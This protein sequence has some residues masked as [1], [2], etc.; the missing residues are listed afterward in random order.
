MVNTE[1]GLK[2]FFSNPGQILFFSAFFFAPALS[3][4]FFGWLNGLLAVP[5]F[6]LLTVNGFRSGL[7]PLRISIMIAGIGALLVHRLEFFLFSL[8]LIPLGYSLFKS[9]ATQESAA[10]T[11]GKGVAVLGLTW[12]VFWGVYGAVM[13]INPYKHLLEMLDLG[14]QQSLEVYT[15]KEAGLPPE[16]IFAV[17][18]VFSGLRKAIPALLP[19]LLAS[20]LVVTVWFNMIISNTLVNHFSKGV[21]PWGAYST[22]ELPEQLVWVPITAILLMLIGKGNVLYSGG[23][24]LM[25]S[26]LLYF[27]QGLAISIALLERWKV[28]VYIKGVLYFMLIIQSYGLVILALL[29]I[30]DTWFNFRKRIEE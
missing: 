1:P 8:T 25:L 30:S 10:V 22:W 2:N 5:V 11:G 28:P 6:Y 7:K 4:S 26:G 14:F 19:G 16:M 15:S 24:L 13:D 20:A 29:G 17:Q 21:F 27:F 23:C 18:E 3:P 9:A 12:L